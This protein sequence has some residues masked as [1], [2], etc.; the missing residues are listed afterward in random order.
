MLVGIAFVLPG[1]VCITL[2]GLAELVL[3]LVRP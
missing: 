1:G 2:A 3:W